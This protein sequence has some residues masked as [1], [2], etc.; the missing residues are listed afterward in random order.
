MILNK[1]IFYFKKKIISSLGIRILTFFNKNRGYFK[2]NGI[3]MFL[4][5][6]DPIDRE[7]IIN[8]EYEKKEISLLIKLIKSHNIKYLID[9]G[10]NCGIYSF[11]IS[12]N[13][14]NLKTFAFEPNNEAFYKLKRTI[15]A[16]IHIFKNIKIFNF[17]LSNKKSKLKMRSL[18]KHGYL[19]TGG[20]TVVDEN[21]NINDHIYEADFDTGDHNINLK[22]SNIAIKIDVEGHELN[23]LLGLKRTLME[24]SC[25]LQIETFDKIFVQ[26]NDFLIKNN[27]KMISENKSNIKNSYTNYFYSNFK[28]S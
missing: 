6:L 15:E 13:L 18:E 21:I 12:S 9:I 4:D 20:S 25:I 11:V 5:F 2:I 28:I 17:G 26:T 16:N 24:N 7:I 22:N 14:K 19:Q 27:F 23:V 1:I 8:Q 3:K 10:A